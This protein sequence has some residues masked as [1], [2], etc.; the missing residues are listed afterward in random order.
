MKSL[1]SSHLMIA[2]VLLNALDVIAMEVRLAIGLSLETNRMVVF[3]IFLLNAAVAIVGLWS[4]YRGEWLAYLIISIA[5]MSLI[6]VPTLAH[7]G[8]LIEI[9]GVAAAPAKV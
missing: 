7:P 8:M 9:E 6:G 5:G 3:P 1:K 4:A 2:A